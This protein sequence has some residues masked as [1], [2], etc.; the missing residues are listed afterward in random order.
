MRASQQYD[1]TAP[2]IFD[3]HNI[4]SDNQTMVHKLGTPQNQQGNIPVSKSQNTLMRGFNNTNNARATTNYMKKRNNRN[5]QPRMNASQ[6][7]L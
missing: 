1:Q 3:I 6:M 2:Q 7:M 4:G 5:G